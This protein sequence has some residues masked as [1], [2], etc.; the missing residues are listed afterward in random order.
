MCVF[1]MLYVFLH[2]LAVFFCIQIQIICR[3]CAGSVLRYAAMH[4]CVARLFLGSVRCWP[5]LQYRELSGS[6]IIWVPG[7]DKELS[8]H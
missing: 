4:V 8:V 1:N 5:L 3:H 6:P 7:K 2:V